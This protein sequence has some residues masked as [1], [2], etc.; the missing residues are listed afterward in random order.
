MRISLKEVILQMIEIMSD[1][2]Q[3][4]VSHVS[5]PGEKIGQ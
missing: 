1:N 2:N 5:S 4:V 3:N